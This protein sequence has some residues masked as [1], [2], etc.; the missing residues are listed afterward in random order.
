VSGAQPDILKALCVFLNSRLVAW[1]FR[2]VVT[3]DARL[4]VNLLPNN[5]GIIPVPMRFDVP[6]L[7]WLCDMLTALYEEPEQNSIEET[8]SLRN[9]AD[10]A[11]LESY[12]PQL[13]PKMDTMRTVHCKLDKLGH[14]AVRPE[15]A[16]GL[17]C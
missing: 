7:A 14:Q 9:A 4:T 17:G 6:V 1:F 12:F 11:V 8:E 10:A 13:F 16:L 15:T 2:K 3:N 5:L